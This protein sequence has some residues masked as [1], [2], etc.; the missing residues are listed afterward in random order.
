MP[1]WAT[2]KI[3]YLASRSRKAGAV[4]YVEFNVTVTVLGAVAEQSTAIPTM[5]REFNPHM[6]QI[7][8][9]KSGCLCM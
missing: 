6:E 8:V 4:E 9:Q 1:Y 5:N 3:F 2:T 7:F